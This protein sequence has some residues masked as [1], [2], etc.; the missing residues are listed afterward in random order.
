MTKERYT[1]MLW[2]LIFSYHANEPRLGEQNYDPLY[3]IKP[4]VNYLLKGPI[5]FGISSIYP[6]K[7]KK[8]HH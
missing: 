1:H 5:W 6:K 4:V 8:C 2:Y 3:K 7:K